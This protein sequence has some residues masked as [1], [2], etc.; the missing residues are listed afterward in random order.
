MLAHAG[1]DVDL[2]K[3]K[4][5]IEITELSKLRQREEKEGFTE[6]SRKAK[7]PFFN[8]GKVGKKIPPGLK[9]RIERAFRKTMKKLGYLEKAS[10][11]IQLH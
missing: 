2:E 11:V 3:V 6:A 8:S 10:G 5:A 4:K 1:V 9:S 7:D